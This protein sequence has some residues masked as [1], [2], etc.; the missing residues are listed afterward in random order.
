M[1]PG[2]VGMTRQ[3][4]ERF[5]GGHQL[6]ATGLVLTDILIVD[7]VCHNQ[8][9]GTVVEPVDLE[10]EASYPIGSSEREL[11]GVYSLWR[12]GAGQAGLPPAPLAK[13][14]MIAES[15]SIQSTFQILHLANLE[16]CCKNDSI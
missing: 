3:R 16:H 2:D 10:I 13:P 1:G 5:V 12:Q 6:Y 9:V 7:D 8:V 15:S 11:Q 14:G 4:T